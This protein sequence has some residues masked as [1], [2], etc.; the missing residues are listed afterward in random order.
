MIRGKFLLERPTCGSRDKSHTRVSERKSSSLFRRVLKHKQRQ[1]NP[2][3]S[4]FDAFSR[5]HPSY[6]TIS[7][8]LARNRK[9]SLCRETARKIEYFPATNLKGRRTLSLPSRSSLLESLYTLFDNGIDDFVRIKLHTR[10]YWSL[11]R[12]YKSEES[13]GGCAKIERERRFVSFSSDRTH[14][15]DMETRRSRSVLGTRRT[16]P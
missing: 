3:F 11:F 7:P 13:A 14:L 9:S 10:V 8:S 12:L 16:R 4:T 1:S 5:P 6:F 15:V 2:S